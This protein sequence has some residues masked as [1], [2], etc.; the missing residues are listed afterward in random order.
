MPYLCWAYND[1]VQPEFIGIN[2][3]AVDMPNALPTDTGE[4]LLIAHNSDY[5]CRFILEYLQNVK[6]IVKSNRFLQAKAI[7]YNPKAKQKINIVVKD[8]YKL[9]PMPLR[10]FCTRFKLDVNKE[11]MPYNVYTYENVNMGA[12]SIRSAL[13]ILKDGD[14]QKLLDNL[15]QWDCTLRKGMDNQMF[16]LIKYS[17]RYCK[18][19]CKLLMDG[20]EVFRRWMLEHTELDV[21]N[22]IT[23]Q[24]MASPFMVKSGCYDNVHQVSGAI[25]QFITKGVVGGR[26]MTNSNKQYHVKKKTADFDACS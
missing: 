25:Q 14:K 13:D 6:P 10:G 17:S 1:D 12:C 5:D 23:I 11:A 21:Y 3:C 20:Y 4:I 2:T 9:I 15:E 26:A 16:D 8:Y 24:S 22:F 7:C 18:M 19:G